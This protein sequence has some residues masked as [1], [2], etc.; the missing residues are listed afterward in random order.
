MTPSPSD[1]DPSSAPDDALAADFEG[2]R[3]DSG[4]EDSSDSGPPFSQQLGEG[5]ENEPLGRSWIGPAL[6]LAGLIALARVEI[7]LRLAIDRRGGEPDSLRWGLLAEW[8][9]ELIQ[10]LMMG[11]AAS[12]V[13]WSARGAKRPFGVA[14]GGLILTSALSGWPIAVA[15]EIP[16]GRTPGLPEPWLLAT[17]C[18]L[19]AA[20]LSA[21]AWFS[22]S[23]RPLR[24]LLPSTP[25]LL[26]C[27][28]AGVVLPGW[29]LM[30]DSQAAPSMPIREVLAQLDPDNKS[31]RVG[32]ED[33]QHPAR[34][35]VLSPF[36]DM[37]FTR[38]EH[39]TGDKLALLM[40]PPC[41][42]SF[43]IPPGAEGARLVLAAQIDGRYTDRGLDVEGRPELKR[44]STLDGHG[45][46]SLSVKFSVE[47]DGQSVFAEDLTH[48]HGEGGQD[49]EW[50]HVGQ[51][52]ALEVEPGQTI[53]LR[54]EFGDAATAKIFE[55][56]GLLCGFGGLVLERW[57][58]A[59]R[60]RSSEE[61]PN[62]LFIT[63]DTLRAD[64]MSC[65]G[66]EKLTTPYIDEL[67]QRGQLFQ[68]AFATSSWT[69]PS[70]ASL[71][72]GLLPYEHGVLS[73]ASCNLNFGYETLAEVLQERGYSTSAI[74]CN[75]L[76]D[77]TRQFDQ[78]FE[79]FDAAA[80][81]RMTDEV[82]DDI[83]SELER[84]ADSRF[85]FYLQLVDPHTPHRPLAS[86]LKRLGGEEPEDFP[87]KVL[88]GTEIDGM[89][90]YA[91][92]LLAKEA[93]DDFGE[94][95][96]EW[97]V[98]PAHA[99]WISDRYDASVGT[100]DLYIG[101]ILRR[102]E[103]LELTEK[104]LIVITSDHGEELLD[105]GMLAHGHALWRE[106]V[107][108]PLILAGPGIP[109]GEEVFSEVSNR[110]L[111]TT[112]AMIGG[113][114]FK[115]VESAVNLLLPESYPT[116]VFYQTSKG[117]WNGHK[118]VE[119]QGLRDEEF[120]VH[121]AEQGGSWKKPAPEGGGMRIFSI[122]NDLDERADLYI[123]PK[124]QP[125]AKARVGAIQASL[126]EQRER[127]RGGSVGIGAGALNTLKALGYVGDDE[128]LEEA[129]QEG[130]D[131]NSPVERN[132]DPDATDQE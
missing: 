51:D 99:Q 18:I 118:P 84:L 25:F 15:E 35:G 131:S 100:G 90:E 86:E 22:S 48:R 81:L 107:H 105:H 3:P 11:A 38:A 45:K 70:T 20:L 74:S 33:P 1:A 76:I 121:F 94:I 69:W 28:L 49:R 14:L 80:R 44:P 77:E 108:V 43:V 59:P 56:S 46:D 67:A 10:G 26:V 125:K 123:D 13:I 2:A 112:L 116:S 23:Q 126:R 24:T 47:Q 7:L 106:L 6:L 130:N 8:P 60:Q 75:P 61:T 95:H 117:Y 124:Y 4:L 64:R 104:T 73:N 92:R 40:S 31:W 32:H 17:G 91:G 29:M 71:F 37:R 53:T 66:Y 103:E 54:T 5:S 19:V 110:H 115:R 114:E 55:Q 79:R 41:E 72:T 68:R 85:F 87:D 82:I 93:C 120:T 101:R 127:K 57:Q 102:L 113:G 34:V 36:S 50:R 132:R 119:M 63:V 111:A 39:D 122:P 9:A 96:P 78:G 52:G 65:Y 16:R 88:A 128:S 27:A 12:V 62:I 42:V 98:P 21:L 30:K 89:D 129:S 97:V 109:E 83:E 58:E